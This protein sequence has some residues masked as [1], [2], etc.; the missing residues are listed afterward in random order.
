MNSKKT[1][2]ITLAIMV[3]LLICLGINS[4]IAQL[5]DWAV[6]TAGIATLADLP[7]IVYSSVK[8]KNKCI[9]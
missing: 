1:F 7:C 5:P 8:R 4:F 6:R 9:S 2:Y 3:L